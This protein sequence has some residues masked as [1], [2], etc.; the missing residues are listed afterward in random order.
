M[1]RAGRSS[2]GAGHDL[3]KP[4]QALREELDKLKLKHED[5]EAVGGQAKAK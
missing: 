1:W 4:D 3:A 2:G 5:T